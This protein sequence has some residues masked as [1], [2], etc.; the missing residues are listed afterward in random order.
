MWQKHDGEDPS[1]DGRLDL[2]AGICQDGE[3]SFADTL[4]C[5]NRRARSLAL[6]SAAPYMG[7][8]LFDG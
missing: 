3:L 1:I 2:A 6:A 8:R 4:A 5:R 7:L